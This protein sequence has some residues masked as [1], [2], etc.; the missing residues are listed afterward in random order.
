MNCTATIRDPPTPQPELFSLCEEEPGG[1]RS[2]SVTDPAP[3][4]RVERHIEEHRIEAC[5]FVQILDAPVP[6]FGIPLV[7]AIRHLDLHVPELVIEV[8]KISSS[9]RRSRRRRVPLV[10]T[11]EQLMEVPT[12][13]SY[14]SLHGL[15][16]QNVDIPVPHGRHGRD[17]ERSSRF[18]PRKEFSSVLRSRTW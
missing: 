7:G 13:V 5:P 10:Q 8:P 2:G 18:T 15:V 9:P 1:R 12:I 17:R 14:S 4:E 16:E 6:Q 11:A 3:Q